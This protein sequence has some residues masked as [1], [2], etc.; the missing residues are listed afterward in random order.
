M[1][2]FISI[3]TGRKGELQSICALILTVLLS[4]VSPFEYKTYQV[5]VIKFTT[6]EGVGFSLSWFFLAAAGWMLN[7]TFQSQRPDGTRNA[8][9]FLSY[10][11]LCL[12]ITDAE[13]LFSTSAVGLLFAVCVS[14]LHQATFQKR[15]EGL[16]AL[17]GFL[18]SLLILIFPASYPWL[19]ILFLLL[20]LAEEFSFRMLA[21]FL[22]G[23]L[24][25][26]YL[27]FSLSYLF[28]Q[29]LIFWGWVGYRPWAEPV[30]MGSSVFLPWVSGLGVFPV[31]AGMTSTLMNRQSRTRISRT[32]Q[33]HMGILLVS[34]ICLLILAS[35]QIIPLNPLSQ[36]LFLLPALSYISARGIERM[37]QNPYSEL[38]LWLWMALVCGGAEGLNRWVFSSFL[39]L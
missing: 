11:L 4:Q 24:L 19:L 6:L 39:P 38:F 37:A 31:I 28:Q 18:M 33:R 2:H 23:V 14:C 27:W 20:I 10:T 8:L 15:P 17:S 25:V 13:Q 3:L 30:S 36:V 5:G 7:Q 1:K 35:T 34:G 22:V 16:V 12:S 9:Y 32:T 29:P 26:P 21:V